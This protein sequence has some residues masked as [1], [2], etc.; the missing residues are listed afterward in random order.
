MVACALR[1]LAGGSHHDIR[2][3]FEM[4]KS[5]YYRCVWKVLDAINEDELLAVRFPDT[6]EEREFMARGFKNSTHTGLFARCIGCIDG[7]L[8]PIRV[9]GM[10]EVNRVSSFYSGHYQRFGIN[11]QACCDF[12][13]KVTAFTVNCA[14]GTNDSLAFAKWG[15]TRLLRETA[16]PDHLYV[17]ADN[18]Y[19][20][21]RY[22]L[23]PFNALE[24][25]GRPD[26]IRY[27]EY[28]AEVR[29]TI[30]RTFGLLVG[31]WRILKH[32]LATKFSNHEYIIEACIRLHNYCIEER[33]GTGTY[34]VAS[35][36]ER[37]RMWNN[38][39]DLHYPPC[40]QAYTDPHAQPAFNNVLRDAMV[41]EVINRGLV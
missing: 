41:Q 10:R 18:G 39:E 8:C 20:Q 32:P 29:S 17:L 11:L 6:R 1:H 15:L 36:V 30:E 22:T 38:G 33:I 19:P 12:N 5:Y 21:V 34:S 40:L 31:K 37:T 9:P 3:S 35:E 4:S 2:R 13:A 25:G 7:M 26:R 16:V 14:G 23:T 27:N 24:T 28:L